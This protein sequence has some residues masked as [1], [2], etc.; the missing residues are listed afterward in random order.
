MCLVV[1][2]GAAVSTYVGET[3]HAYCHTQRNEGRS[4]VN[5]KGKG[6]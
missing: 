2:P 3:E 5:G 6:T 1:A 4:S